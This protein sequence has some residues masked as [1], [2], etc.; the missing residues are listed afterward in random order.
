MRSEGAGIFDALNELFQIARGAK[1][2]SEISHIKLSAKPL[3]GRAD[4]VLKAI[5][6]ARDE[7]LEITQDQ[8]AYTASSTSLGT[9]IPQSAREGG[10]S[11]F[12]ERLADPVEK[13]RI[14]AEMKRTLER[15]N[16]TD[17]SYAYIA[18][19]GKQPALNGKNVVEAARLA[20]G[21][22]S[23]DEQIELVLEIQKNG[24]AGAVF[25]GMHEDDLRAFLR[26][27]NTMIASDSGVRELG[28]SVPHPRGYGNNARVLGQYVREQKVLRLEDAVRRMSSLPAQTFRL[29]D[30]GLLRTGYWADVTL[31]DP[32]TV[33]DPATF[34]DPHHYATGIRDV[35]VNGVPVLR[36]EKHTGAGPGRPVRHNVR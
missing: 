26:H 30:R 4:E 2:R 3:W 33:T 7:G 23:L 20:R 31:F 29:R 14:V 10:A 32:Q 18:S 15:A 11:R 16:R 13:A 28:A 19:Y 35:L 1:I 6:Q 25:H 5:D 12:R 24:S 8:Y 27:P 22:D 21:A 34:S 9:L 36:D 17:Y